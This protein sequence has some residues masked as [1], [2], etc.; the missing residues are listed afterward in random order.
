MWS[1]KQTLANLAAY[2]PNGY[3]HLPDGF[4]ARKGIRSLFPR[5]EPCNISALKNFVFS[6]TGSTKTTTGSA[7]M[8][9]VADGAGRWGIG[10]V[11]SL[12]PL[13]IS[14]A[15]GFVFNYSNDGN[16]HGY[17]V[18]NANV[19]AGIA[20]GFEEPWI[21]QNWPH[22][23]PEGVYL[24]MWV[25]DSTI[26]SAGSNPSH[27]PVNE[28]ATATN[29]SFQTLEQFTATTN[30]QLPPSTDNAPGED[31]AENPFGNEPPWPKPN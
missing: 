14:W 3:N 24:W 29:P 30:V 17:I 7:E 28:A 20:N 21:L 4:D 5:N 1:L 25:E 22:A 13:S 23:F 26:V 31:G 6:L 9:I 11:P 18:N 15:G 8:V 16:G 12:D 19:N 2:P 10:A 27:G